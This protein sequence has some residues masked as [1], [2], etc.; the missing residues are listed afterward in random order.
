M[1]LYEGK[2]VPVEGN[3]SQDDRILIIGWMGKSDSSDL[4]CESKVSEIVCK[5]KSIYQ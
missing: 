2:I 1:I 4:T 5:G 3:S